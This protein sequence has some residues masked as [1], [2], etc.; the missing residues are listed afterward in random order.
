MT[1]GALLTIALGA[2][3]ALGSGCSSDE[4]GLTGNGL[5]LDVS[6]V[7]LAVSLE[8]AAT[9]WKRRSSAAC[10]RTAPA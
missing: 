1:R 9:T 2:L 4:F 8:P 5:P 7:S 3:V 6:Q 10:R